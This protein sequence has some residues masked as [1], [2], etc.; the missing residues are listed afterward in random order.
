MIVLKKI[1]VQ[2]LDWTPTK[3]DRNFFKYLVNMQP[4]G[5]NN[6]YDHNGIILI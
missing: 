4:T 3:H 1:L 2:D 6:I 5:V